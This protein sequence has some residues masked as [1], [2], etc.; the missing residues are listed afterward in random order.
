VKEAKAI[1]T[2][3][4]AAWRSVISANI[5]SNNSAQYRNNISVMASMA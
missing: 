1:E 4:Q 2:Q 5:E 3:Y